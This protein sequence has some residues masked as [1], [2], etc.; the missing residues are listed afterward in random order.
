MSIRRFALE[1]ITVGDVT[2]SKGEAVMILLASANRDEAQFSNAAAIDL[3]REEN[4]H[5]AFGNGPHYCFGAALARLEARVVIGSLLRRFPH[6]ELGV[7]TDQ[8]VWHTSVRARD[9]EVLPVVVHEAAS[10][11]SSP[12]L[13]RPWAICAVG[14]SAP[15]PGARPGHS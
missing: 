3:H 11:E 1:D 13:S 7:P 4:A 5:L 10:G 14:E 6:I 2:I 8:L 9:L 15:L 12:Y